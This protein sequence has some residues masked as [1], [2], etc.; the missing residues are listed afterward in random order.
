MWMGSAADIICSGH[1]SS[2]AVAGKCAA[3]Y[4]VWKGE[5]KYGPDE[6]AEIILHTYRTR[7]EK[8]DYKDAPHTSGGAARV[9]Y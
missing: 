2:G 4:A 6:S 3:Q 5:R 7:A 9:Y 1:R 8:E